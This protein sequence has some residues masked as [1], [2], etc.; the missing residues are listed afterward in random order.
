MG[1]KKK[2]NYNGD[3]VTEFPNEE[4]IRILLGKSLVIPKRV[5]ERLKPHSLFPVRFIVANIQGGSLECQGSG[6]S[7]REVQGANHCRKI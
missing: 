1:F 7:K 4:T 5:F 6:L 3:L 2:K